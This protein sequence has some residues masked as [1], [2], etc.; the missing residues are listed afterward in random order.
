MSFGRF[1]LGYNNKLKDKEVCYKLGEREQDLVGLK[2]YRKIGSMIRKEG[3]YSR[4]KK[5][6]RIGR[7]LIGR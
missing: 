3:C 5:W 6:R 4:R 2:G 1:R 7:L